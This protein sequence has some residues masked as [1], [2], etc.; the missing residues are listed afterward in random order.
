MGDV[1]N[2]NDRLAEKYIRKAIALFERDPPDTEYQR[3]Y[4]DA[5]LVIQRE[6]FDPRARLPSPEADR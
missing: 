3:G 1:V 5:L 6:A 2:F 4:L